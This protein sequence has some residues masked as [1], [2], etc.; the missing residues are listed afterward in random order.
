MSKYL[1]IITASLIVLWTTGCAND[2]FQRFEAKPTAFGGSD[3]INVIADEEVW[4]SDV[5]DT[6]DYYYGSAYIIL[7]QP[8]PLFDVKYFTPTEIRNKEVRRTL[9]VYL[10]LANLEDETSPTTKMLRNDIG[11]DNYAKA[12]QD[13]DFTTKVAKDRWASGQIV[14]Y[15]WGRNKTELIANLKRNFAGISKRIH[16][17]DERQYE[18]T[19]YFGGENVTAGNRI[20][21]RLG[22]RLRVP[23][24]YTLAMSDSTTAWLRRS[25]EKADLNILVHRLPYS[26]KSQLSKSGLKSIRDYVGKTYVSST[27]PDS[28]MR[29]NDVDLPMYVDPVTIDNKYALHGRG[30]WDIVNDYMGGAFVSYLIHDEATG[31]LILVDGFVHA[32]GA[33]KRLFMQQLDYVLRTIKV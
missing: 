10:M 6:L 15:L 12:M 27:V 22:V 21:E 24:D 29:I 25:T 16:K 4:N 1:S 11:E 19:V 2:T 3:K 5:Q 13:P 20:Q 26:D 32:P 28:Y 31:H 14:I 23:E 17:F 7:P 8:E 30:I 18:S 33:K 9:R